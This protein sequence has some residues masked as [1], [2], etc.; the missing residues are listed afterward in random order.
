MK[1]L[2]APLR[3]VPRRRALGAVMV[4]VSLLLG[5]C[6]PTTGGTGTGEQGLTPLSTF[7]ATAAST[8]SSVVADKLACASTTLTPSTPAQLPGTD[9][10]V[11]V[12]TA[13]NGPW[14]LSINSNHALLQSRCKPGMSFEGVWG[15]LA[16]GSGR[17]FGDWVTVTGGSVVPALLWPDVLQK[18][19]AALLLQ[20]L[21]TKGNVLLGPLPVQ[22]VATAPTDTPVCP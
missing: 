4:A 13:A 6:G 14:V 19:S 9:P 18:T 8:C 2:P 5:G 21:D 3:V 11:F 12:G 17:F 10:V 1:A 7:G 15:V 20:V 22:R 16:D